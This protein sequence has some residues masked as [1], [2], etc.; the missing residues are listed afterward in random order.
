MIYSSFSSFTQGPLEEY[1]LDYTYTILQYLLG[2][3]YGIIYYLIEKKNL[4]RIEENWNEINLFERIFFGS[5]SEAT[6]GGE[7]AIPRFSEGSSL[8]MNKVYD[9]RGSTVGL[10]TQLQP[11]PGESMITNP[12][13]VTPPSREVSSLGL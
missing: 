11:T 10:T 4:K 12:M 13:T 1:Y 5:L 3:G 6:I 7:E 9:G 8:S 2:L